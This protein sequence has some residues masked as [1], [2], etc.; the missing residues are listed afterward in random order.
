ME[1]ERT[2]TLATS[3]SGPGTMNENFNHLNH[4]YG[5][6]LKIL[7]TLHRKLCLMRVFWLSENFNMPHIG[8]MTLENAFEN[9]M[10]K[11]RFYMSKSELE[12]IFSALVLLGLLLIIG[13]LIT[14]TITESSLS[15]TIL[16]I[17]LVVTG[18][19]GL[20]ETES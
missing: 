4:L 2:S 7:K 1:E 16:G 8:I 12:T 6:I 19:T 14:F 20:A 5:Y 11:G 13:A 17:A 9:M 18:C 15:L 10:E 3:M